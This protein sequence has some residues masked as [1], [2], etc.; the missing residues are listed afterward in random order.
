MNIYQAL[1]QMTIGNRVFTKDVNYNEINFKLGSECILKFSYEII[2]RIEKE[3]Y[4]EGYAERSVIHEQEIKEKIS[5]A[6]FCN[7]FLG[8]EFNLESEE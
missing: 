7:E 4:G 3:P 6:D 5:I 1:R 2:T 8:N